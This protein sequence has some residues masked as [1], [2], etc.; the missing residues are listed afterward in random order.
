MSS[1]K[2][3]IQHIVHDKSFNIL[4]DPAK[5]ALKIVKLVLE[6]ALEEHVHIQ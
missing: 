5:K 6:L 3:T 1:L 4:V 2:S